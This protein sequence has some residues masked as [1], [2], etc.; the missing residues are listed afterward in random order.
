MNYKEELEMSKSFF[1][2]EETDYGS[3]GR[4]IAA[5]KQ[6]PVVL[7]GEARWRLRVWW[8]KV[9]ETARL[10]CPIGTGTLMATGRIVDKAS[11]DVGGSFEVARSI[12][13]ELISSMIVFGGILV[14]PISGRIC[15]Y[16]QAV[17]DGH[18]T[19][20][21]RWIPPQQFVTD[22]MNLHMMELDQILGE[23]VDKTARE[24]W[25]GE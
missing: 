9:L 17:H 7:S 4:A 22:A 12:N 1:E 15:D 10:L 3:K 24:V 13:D 2:I 19:V 8:E 20:N 16:A 11:P 23:A 18:F 6:F 21:G 25:V 5:T 14:N